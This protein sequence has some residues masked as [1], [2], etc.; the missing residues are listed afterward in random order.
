MD[1]VSAAAE[2]RVIEWRDMKEKNKRKDRT[3]YTHRER[4]RGRERERGLE[5]KLT[6][7]STIM[8]RKLPTGLS[9]Y[10]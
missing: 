1:D 4:D 6:Q 5:I 10:F 8:L 2:R 9:K 3:R 7:L